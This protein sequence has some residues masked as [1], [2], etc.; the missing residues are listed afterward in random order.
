MMAVQR[1]L[2]AILVADVARDYLPDCLPGGVRGLRITLCKGE[3]EKL[4][5]GFQKA[6]LTE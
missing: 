3:F 4:V 2:A 6:G 5:E 1:R